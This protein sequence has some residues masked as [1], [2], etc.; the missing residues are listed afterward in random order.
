MP[1]RIDST[2]GAHVWDTQP[3]SD[4][5]LACRD[6]ELKWLMVHE[7][8]RWKVVNGRIAQKGDPVMNRGNFSGPS[9]YANAQALAAV[10]G[11]AANVR[12]WD[13]AI[14]SPIP[15]NSVQAP[16]AF[17]LWASGL[18]TSS[19]AGQTLT[20]NPAIGTAVAGQA[21]GA[22]AALALGST[23]T[24]AFWRLEY[25]LLIR[26]PGTSGTAVGSG[27]IT[28]GTTAGATPGTPTATNPSNALFGAGNTVATADFQTT[29]Q[30]LLIAAT[31]SAAGVSVTPNVVVLQSLD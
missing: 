21:L 7:A 18:V 11:G 14:Y 29:A 10:T 13:P 16:T 26:T 27:E 9:A 17:R 5:D 1:W 19:A 20:M 23:I 30:G 22:S 6:E 15:V 28:W 24:G 31:P 8:R 4:A 25:G 2:A 12:W 3:M